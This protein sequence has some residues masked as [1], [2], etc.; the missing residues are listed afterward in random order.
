ML[1]S[2]PVISKAKNIGKVSKK[3]I[4]KETSTISAFEIEGIFFPR[5]EKIYIKYPTNF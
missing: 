5:L 3:Y 4:L 1:E 2:T